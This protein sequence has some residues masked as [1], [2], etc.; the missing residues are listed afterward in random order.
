MYNFDA[1][2]KP[3]VKTVANLEEGVYRFE[4]IVTDNGGLTARDTLQ[5]TVLPDTLVT[6]SSIIKRFDGREW[7]DS[8]AIRVKNISSHI[9]AG[10]NYQLFIRSYN[11]L[12]GSS[13]SSVNPVRSGG[14]GI[15]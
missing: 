3:F 15:T 8:C 10:A 13:G 11:E 2:A 7:G 5:V 14:I 4:L 9:P 6:N 1:N 12:F